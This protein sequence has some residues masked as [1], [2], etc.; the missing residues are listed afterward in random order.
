M[1]KVSFDVANS[2][3]HLFHRCRQQT[4]DLFSRS[5]GPMDITARQLSVLCAVA[6]LD[7][8]SQTQLCEVS[9]I[10]RST[11]ADIVRRLVA[12]GWLSR[13]RTSNDARMY[14][15]QITMEG[16]KILD[17]AL[18]VAS[19]VDAVLL[20]AL[21]ADEQTQLLSLLGKIMNDARTPHD[22]SA[23]ANV[24]RSANMAAVES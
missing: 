19:A 17:Q 5:V 23:K 6:V 7:K 4:D 21:T 13:R 16:E 24:E 20:S 22:D 9:S 12:R 10:D 3:A 8:P 18:P 15:V 14:A 1:S 2:V 11:L